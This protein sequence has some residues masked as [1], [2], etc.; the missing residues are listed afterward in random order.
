MLA[1]SKDDRR[2]IFYEFGYKNG[3][4]KSKCRGPKNLELIYLKK[5]K[6]M[7]QC[8]QNCWMLQN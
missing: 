7:M 4:F 6:I 1:K 5:R 3:L 8:L 2:E